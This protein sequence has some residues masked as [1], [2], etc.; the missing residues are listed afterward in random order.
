M[1]P[2][3]IVYEE[4]SRTTR[5]NLLAAGP[6]IA[7]WRWQRVALVT[8]AS[9]MG[10]ALRTAQRAVPDVEWVPVVVPDPGPPMR[11]IRTRY[12]EWAKLLGYALRGWV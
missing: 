7:Q 1:P 11:V 4:E 9:H 10:R 3:A 2:A 6:L 8:S 5:G 12:T